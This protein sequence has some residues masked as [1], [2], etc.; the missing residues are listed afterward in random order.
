MELVVLPG[1]KG[2]FGDTAAVMAEIRQSAAA[3]EA[4]LHALPV[5]WVDCIRPRLR[6]TIDK[7]GWGD[8]GSW[9][10]VR[11][12]AIAKLC[13]LIDAT[14]PVVKALTSRANALQMT[15]RAIRGAPSWDRG[16]GGPCP[17]RGLHGSAAV[18]AVDAANPC[19]LPIG[20]PGS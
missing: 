17:G 18:G 10:A 4:A 14:R 1:V 3:A 15:V 9:P 6:I 5:E 8:P 20:S 12:D 13:T 16:S 7:G 11:V 2:K 19:P